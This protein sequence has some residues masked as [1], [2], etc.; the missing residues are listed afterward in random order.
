SG[1]QCDPKLI[2]KQ[3]ISPSGVRDILNGIKPRAMSVQEIEETIWAFGRA[4]GRM[5][6]SGFDGVQIN[7]AHGYLM[8][9]FLSSYTNRRRDKWGGTL[10][11][12]M[13]FV[14]QV[15]KEIRNEVGNNYPV[16]VKINSEDQIRG[17]VTLEESIAMS[18]KFET[19]GFNAIEVSG[20]IKESG[21][22][23]TKGDIP[24]DL[25]LSR[26]GTAKRFLFRLVEKKLRKGAEFKEGYFLP[27]AE[28]IKKNVAIP[29]ISVGGFR[30]RAMM[31]KALL[32]GQ[33]DL[34]ALS[35]PFIRQ[36]NLVKQMEKSP[37]ADPIN[38]IN[39]NRCTVEITVHYKPLRCYYPPKK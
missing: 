17:G 13:R 2:G 26:L 30:R 4:A 9:Q 21:F 24:K 27:Q 7:G 36:P 12:R 34:I 31:E 19:L 1:R 32:Q 10:E 11:N 14:T 29:I 22:T 18:K 15:Y 35:R 38:C 28:A 25:I 16:I 8:S 6:E 23:I 20:G 3:P 37:N 5:K 39:C 33:A